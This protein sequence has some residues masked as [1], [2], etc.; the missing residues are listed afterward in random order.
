M[1]ELLAPAGS[2]DS[3]V[4]AV[5]NGAD[6]VY[7][8]LDAFNARRGAKNFTEESFGA[9]AEYCRVRGVKVYVTLNVLSTDRELNQVERLAK[10]V[11]RLGADALIVQDL[12]VAR[13]LRQVLPDMPLHASTQMSVHNLDG[14]RRAHEAGITR[15]ILAR[16]LS[17]AHIAYIAKHTPVELET[18]V[19]GALCVCYSGQC[20]MSAAIGGRSA[21]RGTCAQPC[22]L[23]YHLDGITGAHLSLKDQSLVEHLE[24]LETCGVTCIKIEGRMK[25]PEYTAIATR[26]YADAIRE[27][28]LPT[29]GELK[30][31]EAVFSRQGFTDAYLRGEKGADMLGVRTEESKRQFKLFAEVRKSYVDVETGCVPVKFYAMIERGKP[32]QLAVSDTDGNVARTEGDI[33]AY[34]ETREIDASFVETQLA[35]TGGT[36]YVSQDVEVVLDTGLFLA[37]STLNEMR[38]NLLDELT[39]IR[40]K[41]PLRAERLFRTEDPPPKREDPPQL[42]VSVLRTAQ[43]TEG[44]ADLKPSLIYMPLDEILENTKELRPYLEREG[45]KFSAILPRVIWDNERDDLK[46]KLFEVQ[47]FGVTECLAHNMG[48]IEFCRKAGLAVRGDFG[49][50]VFNGQALKTLGEMGLASATASFELKMAQIRDMEKAVDLELIAYG[51]L[52]LMVTETCVMQNVKGCDNCELSAKTV[53]LRDKR[54]IAFPVI[55][56]PGC[57][58]V[59]LNSRKLFLADRADEYMDI[60]LWGVRLSF[61]TENPRECRE[62]LERYLEVGNYEPG[63]YTRGLYYRGVE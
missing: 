20:Y 24:A 46:R 52:P 45:L 35:K 23:P 61:T 4:A 19:H 18:F 55:K 5:Q 33:P 53:E 40:A 2:P 47:E 36:P 32:V 7:L 1:L 16:E 43:L 15:V 29:S 42:N 34:A 21:N 9:A 22:R 3:L 58:N 57:R 14:V 63:E 49:L 54:G 48:H 37:A 13:L 27:K 44:L 39:A 26:V 25:R 30:Q 59:I 41:A 8:G 38:R 56:E 28:R 10:S 31:L 60:G 50:N 62:V 11:S 17:I 6:A 12:G 51:R